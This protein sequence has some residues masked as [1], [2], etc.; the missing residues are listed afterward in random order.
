M[1]GNR[2]LEKEGWQE[3]HSHKENKWTRNK[4]YRDMERDLFDE[5]D[6]YSRKHYK[7]KRNDYDKSD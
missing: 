4:K 2:P 1:S 3:E 5:E 7:R 6:N